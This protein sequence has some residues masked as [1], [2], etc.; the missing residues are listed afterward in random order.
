MCVTE[1]W[2]G[3]KAWVM[4][5][6][7]C[8]EFWVGTGKEVYRLEVQFCNVLEAIGCCL[9]GDI[10]NAVLL[11][12]TILVLLA[13]DFPVPFSPSHVFYFTLMSNC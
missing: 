8:L 5:E 13:L 3:V 12:V 11:K 1:S 9:D 7:K 6:R 10:P 2:E 4:P